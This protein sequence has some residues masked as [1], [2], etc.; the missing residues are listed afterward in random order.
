MPTQIWE[1]WLNTDGGITFAP[2]DSLA[3][4]R[5]QGLLDQAATFL[6]RITAAT[7]EEANAQHN[8]RMGWEEYKPQ[9]DPSPCPNGC[10]A[11]YYPQGYGDCPNCG[12]IE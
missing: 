10:G 7:G 11:S 6:H 2:F 5:S 9:G 1:A 12:H 4:L 3:R 8:A